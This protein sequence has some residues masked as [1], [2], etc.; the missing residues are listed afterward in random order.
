MYYK[1][2]YNKKI[3]KSNNDK[4]TLHRINNKIDHKL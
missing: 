3:D 2:I 4:L 1:E